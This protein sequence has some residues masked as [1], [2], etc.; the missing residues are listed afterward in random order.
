MVVVISVDILIQGNK[1]SES[2]T[3]SLYVRNDGSVRRANTA[4]QGSYVMN[5]AG[6]PH[7]MSTA[8]PG[9][10]WYKAESSLGIS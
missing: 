6:I 10:C 5:V 3:G 4:W 2:A 8:F 7:E 1:A 9:Y